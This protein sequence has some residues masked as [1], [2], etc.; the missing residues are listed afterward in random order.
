[1]IVVYFNLKFSNNVL[2]LLCSIYLYQF[3][4]LYQFLSLADSWSC[5]FH[6][7]NGLLLC[8]LATVLTWIEVSFG[9]NN[10]EFF[11]LN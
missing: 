9:L 2:K 8:F 10:E 11:W 5:V 6:I 7:L 4:F 3:T 1:L